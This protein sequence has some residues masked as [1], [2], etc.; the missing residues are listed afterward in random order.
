MKIFRPQLIFDARQSFTVGYN[1]FKSNRFA[2]A[3]QA[4]LRDT[5]FGVYHFLIVNGQVS[6]VVSCTCCRDAMNCVST[7][8]IQ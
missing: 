8:P 5:L 6:M 3:I 7:V 2:Y 1:G 4:Q